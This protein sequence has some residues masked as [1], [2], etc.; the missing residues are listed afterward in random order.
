MFGTGV[1][2]PT[3]ETALMEINFIPVFVSWRV[4]LFP[5]IFLFQVMAHLCLFDT[6]IP[7][8]VVSPTGL[9]GLQ[10]CIGSGTAT[11]GVLKAFCTCQNMKQNSVVSTLHQ[12]LTPFEADSLFK[13]NH[14][15]CWMKDGI[16]S[17]FVL[18]L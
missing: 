9:L 4:D 17:N 18:C 7:S 14:F 12:S 10:L 16:F 1:V 15:P 13:G 5:D 2:T 8:Q 11:S 6:E 3:A